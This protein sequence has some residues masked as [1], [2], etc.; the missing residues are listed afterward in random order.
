M[1]LTPEQL[2][3]ALAFVGLAL[4]LCSA[5]LAIQTHRVRAGLQ[6]TID[7]L[8]IAL[9]EVDESL[10][11]LERSGIQAAGD[12]ERLA[13][14]I[15]EVAERAGNV[16]ILGVRPF[17]GYAESLSEAAEGLKGLAGDVGSL[18][19]PDLS[20][21]RAATLSA[22]GAVKSLSVLLYILAALFALTGAGMALGGLALRSAIP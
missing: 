4:L 21:A 10:R 12:L 7:D 11:S 22:R 18:E 5:A 20:A 8:S 15:E 19:V 9:D 17:E 2:G 14:S 13:D 6:R 3:L 1:T 16:S